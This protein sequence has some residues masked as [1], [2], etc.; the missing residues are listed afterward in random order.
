MEEKRSSAAEN[1]DKQIRPSP[2]C[3]ATNPTANHIPVLAF[4]LSQNYIRHGP[5]KS[6]AAGARRG[7]TL[8]PSPDRPRAV[9]LRMDLI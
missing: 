1:E 6:F 9:C 8:E 7:H 3:G 4:P 2:G 5:E